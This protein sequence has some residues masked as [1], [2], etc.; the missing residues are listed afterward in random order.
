MDKGL[1]LTDEESL[2]F[3][4]CMECAVYNLLGE[5]RDRLD[6]ELKSRGANKQIMDSFFRMSSML[7]QT[8]HK[9]EIEKYLQGPKLDWV[10]M[11]R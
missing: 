9:P 7:V 6:A 10:G 2:L 8:Y 1:Y 5:P 11:I 4:K 3:L